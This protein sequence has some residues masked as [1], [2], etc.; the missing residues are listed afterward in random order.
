MLDAIRRFFKKVAPISAAEEADREARAM[1][2]WWL[3]GFGETGHALVINGNVSLHMQE[4]RDDG[5]SSTRVCAG[6]ASASLGPLIIS[7]LPRIAKPYS[8]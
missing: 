2:E 1:L 8:P 3:L 4:L 6:T 7:L 5:M